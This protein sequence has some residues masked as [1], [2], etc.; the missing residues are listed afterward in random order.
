MSFSPISVIQKLGI[1]THSYIAA[2][3]AAGAMRVSCDFEKYNELITKINGDDDHYKPETFPMAQML[4][5]YLV[6]EVV[7]AHVAGKNMEWH[8]PI[9]MDIALENAVHFVDT[10]PWHWPESNNGDGKVTRLDEV[11]RYVD[12]FP[13][14]SKDILA[15]RL[16]EDFEVTKPTALGWLRTLAAEE[17]DDD[18]PEA[19]VKAEPKVKGLNKG[20][21]AVDIVKEKYNG[22]N[23][24]EVVAYI[25]KAL[26]TTPGGAQTFYYAAIKK[27]ELTTEKPVVVEAKETTQD[28]LRTIIDADP[29]ITR[30]GFI[31]KAAEFGVKATTAQTYY[32]SLTASMGVERQGNG[33]RGRKR[34]GAVSRIDQVTAFVSENRGLTKAE[35]MTQLSE[36][37]TVSKVSAQSYYYAA[38]KA[39]KEQE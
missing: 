22:S 38:L 6:Q 31:E 17:E 29:S 36:K 8:L 5:G 18:A 3:Q 30:K 35:I 9:A 11:R 23:K 1:P 2:A 4:F 28:R 21:Q 16:C 19:K 26:N 14:I 7:R 13:G 39:L 32:Y 24:A 12:L 27:L 15:A 10:Q 37:F 33:T 25:A 20:A 34:E